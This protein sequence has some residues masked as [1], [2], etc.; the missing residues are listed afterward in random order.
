MKIFIKK[1]KLYIAL[2][3]P[4]IITEKVEQKWK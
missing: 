1:S 4:K 3:Q 2:M